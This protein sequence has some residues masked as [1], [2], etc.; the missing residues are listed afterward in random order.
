MYLGQIAVKREELTT[1]LR[2]ADHL[3]IRGLAMT[4]PTSALP[5]YQSFLYFLLV[6]SVFHFEGIVF[7]EGTLLDGKILKGAFLEEGAN[8]VEPG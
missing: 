1:F 5:R 6:N 7:L 2:S 3:K 8:T 4:S